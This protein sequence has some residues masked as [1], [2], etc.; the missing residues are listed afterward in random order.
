VRGS[1]GT[2][3]LCCSL[4]GEV[5]CGEYCGVDGGVRSIDLV[6][7]EVAEARRGMLTT[8]ARVGDTA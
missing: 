7:D 2:S 6:E 5:L 4:K 8:A 1:T 3:C